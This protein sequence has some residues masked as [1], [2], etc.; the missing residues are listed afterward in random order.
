VVAAVN[1]HPSAIVDPGAQLGEGVEIGAFSI[2]GPEVEIGA[3]THVGPHCSVHGPTKIGEDNRILG[4]AAIGGEAQ[5][6]K[7][8]GERSELIIGHHNTIR[9]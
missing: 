9:A 6:K 3:R 2:I 7:F 4:H 5:D 1:I 8:A